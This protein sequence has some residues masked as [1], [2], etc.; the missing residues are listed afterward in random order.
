M[1][2][3]YSKLGGC[4]GVTTKLGPLARTD[5]WAGVKGLLER[6]MTHLGLG[7]SLE[8]PWEC[9]A[10][11]VVGL[12]PSWEVVLTSWEAWVGLCLGG[13]LLP[14]LR[15][16]FWLL[17]RP[18]WVPGGLGG[19]LPSDEGRRALAWEREEVVA[20]ER[21]LSSPGGIAPAWGALA[22]GQEEVVA[23][24]RL[25]SSPGGIAPAWG[26]APPSLA[27][28]LAY[29]GGGEVLA[30]PWGGPAWEDLLSSLEGG[31]A[32]GG[33]LPSLAWEI[34]F[35]W[36]FVCELRLW[37]WLLRLVLDLVIFPSFLLASKLNLFSCLCFT[38]LNLISLTLSTKSWHSLSLCVEIIA[39]SCDLHSSNCLEVLSKVKLIVLILAWSRSFSAFLSILLALVDFKV[40]FSL[41]LTGI[42][43][44]WRHLK[45]N[46][47]WFLYSEA[48]ILSFPHNLNKH[49]A[50]IPSSC[51]RILCRFLIL[52]VKSWRIV[53]I[54][55]TVH[56]L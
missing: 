32:W 24:E 8:E 17:A 34:W 52:L 35:T 7:S 29:E 25:L 13:H 33:A 14:C 55:G 56:W 18:A 1:A 21:L 45:V 31:E 26:G 22:W 28:L 5:L 49:H 36:L 12:L 2:V 54:S 37:L 39:V 46:I 9:L 4:L 38:L 16:L 44:L 6:L 47:L 19:L 27:W 40:D 43:S 20:W 51:S 50:S 53:V 23:W 10:G 48:L 41:I 30:S 15:V 11:V 3:M 42:K